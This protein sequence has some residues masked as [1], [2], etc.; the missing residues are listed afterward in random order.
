MAPALL[1]PDQVKGMGD[2]LVDAL[3]LMKHN[4]AVEKTQAGF[5]ALCARWGGPSV[6]SEGVYVCWTLC[7]V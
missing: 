3:C 7:G 2:D 6:V 4:G 5:E 1:S